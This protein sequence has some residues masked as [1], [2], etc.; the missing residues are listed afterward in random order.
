VKA[1]DRPNA[2]RL[3]LRSDLFA[4]LPNVHRGQASKLPMKAAAAYLAALR[5]PFI[6]L[7]IFGVSLGA[8]YFLHVSRAR[9]Y[10]CSQNWASRSTTR[11]AEIIN[12]PIKIINHRS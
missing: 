4:G 1:A 2:I 12:E 10:G 7:C 9:D 6:L 11:L 5:L 8:H 3:S